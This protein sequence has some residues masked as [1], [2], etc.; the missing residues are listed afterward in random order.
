M[1][2]SEPVPHNLQ[3]RYK[4]TEWS[5]GEQLRQKEK[6][7]KNAGREGIFHFC[8]RNLW[9]LRDWRHLRKLLLFAHSLTTILVTMYCYAKSPHMRQ[10]NEFAHQNKRSQKEIV[11][12][13]RQ[14]LPQVLAGYHIN[15]SYFRHN[16]QL[17]KK[18]K[19]TNQNK[20][21]IMQTQSSS[22][23]YILRLISMQVFPLDNNDCTPISHHTFQQMRCKSKH[24][25]Q[26]SVCQS[27][28]AAS[29]TKMNKASRHAETH[30]GLWCPAIL[31]QIPQTWG[32]L[33]LQPILYTRSHSNNIVALCT[34]KR[35]TLHS[36]LEQV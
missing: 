9:L 33:H 30:T 14:P 1:L 16:L 26:R 34:F 23:L 31:P 12:A 8:R 29:E 21:L 6:C 35:H 5:R 20:K 25:T 15:P 11:C 28:F 7:S 19:S 2:H 17:K 4:T 18:K 36:F 24:Q 10:E 32:S 27:H 13:L 3:L 22:L